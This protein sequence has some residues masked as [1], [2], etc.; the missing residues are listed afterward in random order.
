MMK[1]LITILSSMIILAGC[2]N[3]N[4]KSDAYGNFEAE[5]VIISSEMTGKLLEFSVEEGIT[6]KENTIVGLIDTMQLNLQKKSLLA[7]KNVIRTKYSG[8][9]AQI[10]VLKDQIQTAEKDRDRVQRMLEGKAA[11]EK[12]LDDIN[13]RLSV[14]EKQISQVNAQNPT[15]AGELNTIDTQIDQIN[16]KLNR[17]IV[18]NPINGTVLAKYTDKYEIAVQGKPL[19]KIANLDFLSLKA[20]VSGAQL[21]KIIIGKQVK[22]LIDK[23]GISNRE[24]TGTVTWV[25]PKAEF[26]PKIIQ[27]KEE[28]VNMVYA[29]KVKVK[30]D[31]S[32]KIGM[33]GEIKL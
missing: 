8:L 6:L 3:N 20:Y 2:G 31:G 16:D 29:I 23:D 17:S 11:T 19:Y 22:V 13:G 10:D 25:S 18:I 14:L 30:N 5:E 7:Q 9:Y 33:P 26:T 1:T 4:D 12:Q 21:S 15:I 24:M 32:L 28:R 27:T